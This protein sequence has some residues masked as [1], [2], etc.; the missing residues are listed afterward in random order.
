VVD[1]GDLLSLLLQVQD[2]EHGTQMMNQRHREDEA[3]TLFLAGRKNDC[4][5]ADMVS[6]QSQHPRVE[7]RLQEELKT[8]LEWSY[9]TNCC[10]PTSVRYTEGGCA[11]IQCG[12]NHTCMGEWAGR[13]TETVLLE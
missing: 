8:V 3:M 2:E 7:A 4:Q 9:C 13:L 6:A 11:E 5:R 12:C 10:R 1:T